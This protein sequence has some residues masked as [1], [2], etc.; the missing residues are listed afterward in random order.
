M[1]FL[2]SLRRGWYLVSQGGEGKGG[3]RRRTRDS[4]MVR[5]SRGPLLEEY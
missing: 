3:E 1:R 2:L 5:R 4:E